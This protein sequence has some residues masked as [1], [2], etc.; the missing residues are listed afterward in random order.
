MASAVLLNCYTNVER[1]GP[2]IKPYLVSI[3]YANRGLN[4][5]K[6][7]IFNYLMRLFE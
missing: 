4:A 7:L 2:R 5:T 6:I 1:I 3:H